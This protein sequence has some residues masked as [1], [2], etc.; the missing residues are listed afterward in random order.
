MWVCFELNII[1]I[2]FTKIRT[3]R[4]I[5]RVLLWTDIGLFGSRKSL[6]WIKWYT[7][8]GKWIDFVI[9]CLATR[10]RTYS[11]KQTV[12]SKFS[13]ASLKLNI[14]E[15]A[16]ELS[17]VQIVRYACWKSISELIGWLKLSCNIFSWCVFFLISFTLILKRHKKQFVQT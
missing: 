8:R 3:A 4:C 11:F 12:G 14:T 9:E 5:A 10:A 2:L 1:L 17:Q 16:L 6:A 15:L 13:E 7:A